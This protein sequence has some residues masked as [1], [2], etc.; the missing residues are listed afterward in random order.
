[1]LAPSPKD[2]PP[3]P[4]WIHKIKHDGF[5]IMARRDGKGVRLYTR[6]GYDFADRF[7]QIAEAISSLPVQSC[8]ID[9]EAIVVD[10]RGLSVF[11]FL[12]YRCHDHA[13]ILCAFDLIELDGDDLRP[14]PIERRKDILAK[15]LSRPN[16]GIAFNQ[17]YTCDGAV[18]YKHVCTFGCEGMSRRDSAPRTDPAAQA[19]GSRSRILRYRRCDARRKR[20]GAANGRVG[21]S[22]PPAAVVTDAISFATPTGRRWPRGHLTEGSERLRSSPAPIVR[23]YMALAWASAEGVRTLRI[24]VPIPRGVGRICWPILFA[25]CWRLL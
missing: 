6:N 9:G 14:L 13:A 1:V 3:G 21:E 23:C 25:P 16:Q 20:I 5:R 4:G 2:R 15:L 19:I 7:P 22:S 11:D 17:H 24:S 10:E 12:R 8:F 18:I